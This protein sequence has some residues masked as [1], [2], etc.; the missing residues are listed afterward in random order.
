[1]LPLWAARQVLQLRQGT[2]QAGQETSERQS[3]G[4]CGDHATPGEEHRGQDRRPGR[5]R[6]QSAGRVRLQARPGEEQGRQG[7]RRGRWHERQSAGRRG[8]Q[9]APGEGHRTSEC[10]EVRA[11]ART[12]RGARLRYHGER[13]AGAYGVAFQ[14]SAPGL[15]MVARP[16]PC[17]LHARPTAPMALARRTRNGHNDP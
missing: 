5:P 11:S 7:A 4:R 1:M 12:G 10:G 9:A 8:L 14:C 17:A 2:G 13:A 3:A 16:G 15:A 6:C